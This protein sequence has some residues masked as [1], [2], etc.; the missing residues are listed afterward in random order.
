MPATNPPVTTIRQTRPQQIKREPQHRRVDQE[1]EGEVRG[2]AVVADARLVDETARD[3]VP[4]Q[5]SLQRPEH[6]YPGKTIREATVNLPAPPE[7]DE[8]NEER[9]PDQPAEQAMEVLEPEDP[10]ECLHAHAL[11]DLPVFGR[12][13]VLVEELLPVPVAQGRHDADEGLPL[14][15][16]QAG[17]GEARDAAQHHHGEDERATGEE[18]DRDGLLLVGCHMRVI[19]CAGAGRE[20]GEKGIVSNAASP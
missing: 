7:P 12:L 6:E 2:Q 10:L 4:S 17:M 16:G 9:K 13:A 20:R 5:R 18:P 1:G 15:N 14:R 11:V 3:H 19:C 8:R